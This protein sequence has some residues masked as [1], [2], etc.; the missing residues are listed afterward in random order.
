MLPVLGLAL[1]LRI[2]VKGSGTA[3]LVR[4][5]TRGPVCRVSATPPIPGMSPPPPPDLDAQQ[6]RQKRRRQPDCLSSPLL[7][8]EGLGSKVQ[9]LRLMAH[10]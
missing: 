4:P 8:T 5:L 3:N 9:G 2:R 7:L 1:G 6:R 10:G